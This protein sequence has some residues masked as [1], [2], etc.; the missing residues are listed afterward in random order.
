MAFLKKLCPIGLLRLE[1]GFGTL[2]TNLS[3]Y[4]V[5]KYLLNMVV[6]AT[7]DTKAAIKLQKSACSLQYS[8]NANGPTVFFQQM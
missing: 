7:V 2:P 1:V 3:V 5:F 6:D 8:P 4:V